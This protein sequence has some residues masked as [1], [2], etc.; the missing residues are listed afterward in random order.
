MND[1]EGQTK[2]LPSATNLIAVS[3]QVVPNILRPHGL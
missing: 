2:S 1:L 3:L